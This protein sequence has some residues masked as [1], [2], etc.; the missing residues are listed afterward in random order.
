MPSV[1]EW[2]RSHKRTFKKPKKGLKLSKQA[3]TIIW[4]LFGLVIYFIFKY[5]GQILYPFIWAMITAYLFAPLI[6]R[7][8]TKTKLPRAIWILLVYLIVGFFIYW[9]LSVLIPIINTQLVELTSA[10][11]QTGTGMLSR[12]YQAG[13]GTF[14]GFEINY[15][16][17]I[18][19]MQVW[20]RSEA[21]TLALPVLLGTIERFLLFFL[22]LVFTFYILLDGEKYIILLLMLI[23]LKYRKEVT[24][25]ARD[26]NRTLGAY[27][28]GLVV[29]IFLMGFDAWI[30]LAILKVDYALL[31]AVATGFLEIIPLIGPIV[32][33]VLV[34]LV[35]LYQPTVAYGLTNV[36]LAAILI[37]IYFVLRQIEDYL[38]IPNVVGRFIHVHPIIVIFSIMIGAKVAGVLGVFL[39]LPAAAVLKILFYYFYPKLTS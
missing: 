35:A 38:I 30:F 39:A 23:P 4:I 32:A 31:L 8:E 13:K 2:L 20:V 21:P 9:G 29:L 15:R 26:I 37:I 3:K 22:Y 19:Q 16:D 28:R 27:I 12:L 34:V 24:V 18:A 10:P 7:L 6:Y 36:S 33:T 5:V 25:V 11:T 17:M 1:F 14:L